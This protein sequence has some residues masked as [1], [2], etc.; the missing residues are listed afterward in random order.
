M[1]KKA[2]TIIMCLLVAGAT[3][4]FAQKKA[5][6]FDDFIRIR[7]VGDPQISPDG[8]RIAF[9]VSVVDRE[10][11]LYHRDIWIVPAKGG[12]PRPLTSNPASDSQPRWS[13]D[14]KKIAF[15]SSRS[16]TPQIWIMPSDGGEARQITDISTGASGPMWSPQGTHLAFI[17]TV[18]AE[19]KDDACNRRLQA[20]E[21]ARLSTGKIFDHLMYRHFDHF[22]NRRRSHV[23][24]VSAEGGP[25]RDLS[26]GDFD[27]PPFLGSSHDY[28]F[29]A[30]G[31]SLCFARNIDPEL[32]LGLGTNNDLFLT[33]I[34]GGDIRKITSNR[35]NDN[36]P[37]FSPDGRTIAYR[38]M[39]RPGFEADKYTLML[40]N[41]E[42]QT[43][44][45]LSDEFDRSVGEFVW[46]PDGRWIYFNYEDRGRMAV[47]RISPLTKEVQEITRDHFLSSL[48]LSADGR[49][50]A[51]TNQAIH[52]PPEVHVLNPDNGSL[53][54]ISFINREH[55]ASVDMN[56][57]EDF[58]FTGADGEKVHGLLVKPPFFDPNQKYPLAMLIHGGP[59]N[60]WSD[61]F[62]FRWSP[63]MFAAEGY[64]TAQINFHGS[65]GYGQKFTDSITGHW[66]SRPYQD[67]MK[68]LDYLLAEHDFIDP[69][70]IGAAGASF[71]G[72]MIDWIESQTD[73]FNCLITHSGLY[74]L[75]S[76]H[77]ATEELWFP[78]WELQ[79]TP[80]TSTLYKKWSASSYVPNFKTPCLIIHGQM[81]YR[82]P[83]TQAFQFFTD[84]QR[85]GVP[86]RLLYFPDE[87]HFVLKPANSEL[88]WKTV[89]EWLNRWV[90]NPR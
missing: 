50:L 8:T 23:F 81:D 31:Q 82:V 17:S 30:D 62:H 46:S 48:S 43:H 2:F 7:R 67:I 3:S 28:A 26:P 1:R 42:E 21:D 29:S 60:A 45:A 61:N 83:V 64:V 19:C 52:L 73:R 87:N 51:C 40:F 86:S 68:G 53:K 20:E 57:V 66:G 79:G 44:T 16:G 24:V 4:V 85:M 70:R 80:W 39:A 72:Y 47:S 18:F 75:Q 14:G 9:V 74:D 59:Q 27:T 35:A 6:T 49:I 63:Q 33:P 84:L 58:W 22:R 69:Q 55:L 11:D 13:P 5:L 54:Q 37:H 12:E 71:G 36:S 88:W 38:A 34:T 78:E 89:H 90:K 77:G 76:F 25:A 15:I 65:T 10:K 56:P 41:I 32:K